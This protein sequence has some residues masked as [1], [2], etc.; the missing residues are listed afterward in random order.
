[1][2]YRY[3]LLLEADVI[4]GGYDSDVM[5]PYKSDLAAR[6][7]S[8]LVDGWTPDWNVALEYFKTHDTMAGNGEMMIDAIN[9]L[10]G[11]Y[12]GY[13]IVESDSKF[14]GHKAYDANGSL[15]ID[16]MN[17][18]FILKTIDDAIASPSNSTESN[19]AAPESVV[20]PALEVESEDMKAAREF[21]N[22][23]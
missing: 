9:H 19:P 20:A 23:L 1:M 3:M 22:P 10:G 13:K 21:L 5:P 18:S 4:P 14:G 12:R 6:I 7:D 17:I 16:H 11:E 2:A 15:L 8:L